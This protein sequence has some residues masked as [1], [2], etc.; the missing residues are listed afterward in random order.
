VFK[1]TT[2]LR[3]K[4]TTTL[5]AIVEITCT[6]DAYFMLF[7]YDFRNYAKISKH[8][9]QQWNNKRINDALNYF[10]KHICTIRRMSL[11]NGG[12]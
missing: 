10:T 12:M 11:R 3:T 7:D 4:N 1:F 8:V 6:S 5:L 9:L 2:R